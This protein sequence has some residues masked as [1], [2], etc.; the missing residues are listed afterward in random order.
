M[1]PVSAA[2][3]AGNLVGY[4]AIGGL[5]GLAFYKATIGPKDKE[6]K[7]K[8]TEFY[9]KHGVCTKETAKDNHLIKNEDLCAYNNKLKCAVTGAATGAFAYSAIFLSRGKASRLQKIVNVSV[10]AMS[11]NYL[12]DLAYSSLKKSYWR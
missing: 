4:S 10:A 11:A 1:N 2:Y 12:S 8:A 9:I 5:S 3:T 7:E 6:L